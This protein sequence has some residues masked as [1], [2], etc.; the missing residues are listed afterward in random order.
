MSRVLR[1]CL[2]A[3]LLLGG[4]A[5]EPAGVHQYLDEQTAIT[6]RVVGAPFIYSREAPELAANVRDYLSLGAV[7]LNNMGARKYYLVLVAW[8]TIDRKRLGVP[9]A[10]LPERI[11]M[12]VG[13]HDRQFALATHTARTIG[14][15]EPVLRPELGYQ[16]ESWYAFTPAELRAF[17]AQP[18][19]TIELVGSDLA[20]SFVLW[21]RA[22]AAFT[23]FVDDMVEPAAIVPAGR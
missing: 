19:E 10:A 12:K 15:G 22:D 18:P 2:V 6:I 23:A 8:S 14:V 16:G 9:A 13:G 4:C 11:E 21:Q 17:A 20:Q 1:L 7:E 3:S 5:T